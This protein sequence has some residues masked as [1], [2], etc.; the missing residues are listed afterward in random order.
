MNDFKTT[1]VE[2]QL[3]HIRR[4]AVEIIRE[5]ELFEKLKRAQH[6]E[7]HLRTA[8]QKSESE[9]NVIGQTTDQAVDAVD[10]FL[11]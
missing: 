9:L 3:E 11:D 10:K 6:T 4:G 1:P 7:V 5:E 2:Q 8:E